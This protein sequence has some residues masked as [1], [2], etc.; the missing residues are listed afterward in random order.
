MARLTGP[1]SQRAS[2]RGMDI[3]PVSPGWPAFACRDNRW[4]I[5]WNVDVVGEAGAGD[6][7]RSEAYG[8]C[9]CAMAFETAIAEMKSGQRICRPQQRIG[10]AVVTVGSNGA[11]LFRHRGEIGFAKKRQIA[12]NDEE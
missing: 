1:P 11:I 2:A 12:C 7:F 4:Q 10:A 9:S 3:A 5:R 8:D 6:D